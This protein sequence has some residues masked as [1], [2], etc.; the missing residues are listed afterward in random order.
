MEKFKEKERLFIKTENYSKA[1][2][3]MENK[4]MGFGLRQMENLYR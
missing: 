4:Q 1:F 2:F 3:K